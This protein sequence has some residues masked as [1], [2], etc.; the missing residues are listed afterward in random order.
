MKRE[1]G[2][3]RK[4]W[5]ELLAEILKQ[6]DRLSAERKKQLPAKCPPKTSS[7]ISPPSLSAGQFIV[8]TLRSVIT[9]RTLPAGQAV[10][11]PIDHLP[12][13]THYS[14]SSHL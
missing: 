5:S 7:F 11:L 13:A 4:D 9:V 3:D 1:D 10:T 2:E 14:H 12:A 6:L 8:E